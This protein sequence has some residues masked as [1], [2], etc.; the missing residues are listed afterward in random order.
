MCWNR[1]HTIN[2]MK[3]RIASYTVRVDLADVGDIVKINGGSN[4]P[5]DIHTV[6]AA[7]DDDDDDDDDDHDH[8]VVVVA[9][10]RCCCCCCC[11]VLLV[12]ISSLYF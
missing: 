5:A 11:C 7:D 2:N 12:R 3:N 8:D 10:V 1:I 4:V 9:V 6:A